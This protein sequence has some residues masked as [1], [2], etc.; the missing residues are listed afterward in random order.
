VSDKL[1]KH[2]KYHFE[3]QTIHAGRIEEDQHGALST[4]IYQNVTFTFDNVEHGGKLFAKEQS[5]YWYSRRNNPTTNELEQ[6]IA[7]LEC[8]EDAIAFSSGMGAISASLLSNLKAGDHIIATPSLYGCTFTLMHEL[9]SKFNISV[10]HIDLNDIA[11]VEDAIRPNTKLI[12]IE[13]PVNPLLDVVDLNRITTLAKK[14][15]LLTV[16][17]NTLMSPVLQQPAKHGVDIVVHSATK[18][19][20]GHGDVL[21]GVLCSSVAMVENVRGSALNDIGAVIS[22]NDAWLLMRGLKTLSLRV[23]KHVSNAEK[24]ATFLETH[25]KI[26]KVYYPGLDS[27]PAK[28]LMGTQMYGGGG[29]VCF[30]LNADFTQTKKFMNAVELCY[31][32][33][34]L[35]DPE[36]LISHPASMSASNVPEEERLKLGITDGMIRLAVGAFL[37]F[38]LECI[39]V[40][41]VKPQY[42]LLKEDGLKITSSNL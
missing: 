7:I 34:S 30:E 40:Y 32:A 15:K 22:P 14:H 39:N 33:V 31:R 12:Y 38:S 18:Y 29:V 42:D 28:T 10:S 16:C 25:S 37:L 24:I 2:K 36:T 13:T 19:L 8:T 20:N 11:A 5:G 3:T 41:F 35:G 26:K 4:P 9:L 1:N 21:A 27:H 17:D 6:R 23:A